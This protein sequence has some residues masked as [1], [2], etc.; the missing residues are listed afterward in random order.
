VSSQYRYFYA[1]DGAQLVAEVEL[2]GID[3]ATCCDACLNVT[4]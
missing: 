2:P 4:R 1:A 3:V